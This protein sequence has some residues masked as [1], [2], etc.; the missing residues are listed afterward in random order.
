[1]LG[2]NDNVF[3][4]DDHS[5]RR[6]HD[7]DLIHKFDLLFI[8]DNNPHVNFHNVDIEHDLTNV[9]D[10]NDSSLYNDDHHKNFDINNVFNDDLL[11]DNDDALPRGC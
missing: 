8:F 5:W 1:M 4:H 7:I 3:N 2:Y 11:D 6:H 10:L 9:D